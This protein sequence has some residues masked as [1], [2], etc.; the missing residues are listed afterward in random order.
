MNDAPS[1]PHPV[2]FGF[3]ISCSAAQPQESPLERT[4]HTGPLTSF[5]YGA[6]TDCAGGVATLHPFTALHPWPYCSVGTC[7]RRLHWG[8]S[9]TLASS[10]RNR[11]SP[12]SPPTAQS[13]IARQRTHQRS[14]KLLFSTFTNARVNRAGSMSVDFVRDENR[15]GFIHRWRVFS[16]HSLTHVC[17]TCILGFGWL[18][19]ANHG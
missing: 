3:C 18:S 11:R 4:S 8:L 10:A 19:P 1:M 14:P 15:F 2:L 17:S 6:I 7:A 9:P 5:A 13:E 12:C 16:I